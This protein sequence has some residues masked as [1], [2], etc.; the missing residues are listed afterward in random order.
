MSTDI[1]RLTTSQFLALLLLLF[2]FV[3]RSRTVATGQV[4]DVPHK[5]S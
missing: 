5:D 1:A 2:A 4:T 3:Q